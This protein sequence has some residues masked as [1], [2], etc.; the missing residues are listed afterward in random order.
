M[1]MTIVTTVVGVLAVLVIIDIW[2]E[3]RRGK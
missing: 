2:L 1:I 3:R